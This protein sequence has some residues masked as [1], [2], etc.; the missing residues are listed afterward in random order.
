MKTTLYAKD[1]NGSIR[2]WSVEE[3]TY[4]LIITHGVSGGCIQNKFEQ[5]EEGLASRDLAEQVRLRF[6]SR[7]NK[8]LDQGY[9]YD[10]TQAKNQP[11]TNCLGLLK[12][13][14]AQSIK[15]VRNI[16]YKDAFYQHKYDGNRCLITKVGG[17]LIAYTRNGKQI[18]TINHIL[19]G[20]Q[21]EEDQTIDG[22]LYCHGVK[23]Q[24]INSWVKREQ[25]NTLKLSYRVYDI[26]EDQPYAARLNTLTD[27][28]LGTKAALVPT[29]RVTQQSALQGLLERSI[30]LGYEGG[31]LRWDNVVYE[32]GKRSKSLVK[33]KI[34]EEGE[35]EIVSVIESKD[36]WARFRLDVGN[37]KTVTVSAPGTMENKYL[38]AENPED[39]I[40]KILTIKY[41]GL[42]N[43]GKPFQ[44]IAVAFREDI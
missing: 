3:D 21:L 42:T 28:A 15:N 10:L 35:F 38:I 5:I 2:H 27:L 24:T 7:I 17:H 8:K 30:K 32:D 33:L 13:M 41:F 14:L 6:N 20:I 34:S 25:S 43:S 18:K 22:E 23:L 26:I 40:G 37:K 9:V 29:I 44:P 36:G 4:G 1:S 11:R 31:I 19:Q 16:N 39:Y 12:P